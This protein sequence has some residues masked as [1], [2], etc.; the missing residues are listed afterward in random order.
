[1]NY[2][3]SQKSGLPV[4]YLEPVPVCPLFERIINYR[5]K[6]RPGTPVLFS[7]LTTFETPAIST[8]SLGTIIQHRSAYTRGKN[9]A[10]CVSRFRAKYL[11]AHRSPPAKNHSAK[12]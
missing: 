6:F 2:I 1:M 8:G 11:H 12:K 7:A 5:Y 3:Y 10:F 9:Q 4:L